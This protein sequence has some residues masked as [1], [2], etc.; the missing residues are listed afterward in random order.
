MLESLRSGRDEVVARIQGALNLSTKKEA[1]HIFNAVI[2]CIEGTLLNNVG[3]D[4]F[5]IK[6]KCFG[7]FS[8]PHKPAILR[9]PL[10]R[11]R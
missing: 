9:K 1:E 7:K 6:R 3:S 11:A 4:G 10:S 5:T 8:V 2:D